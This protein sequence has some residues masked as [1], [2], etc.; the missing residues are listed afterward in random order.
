MPGRVKLD[1]P[2]FE[3]CVKKI[4]T[5]GRGFVETDSIATD[6]SSKSPAMSEFD[7]CLERLFNLVETYSNQVAD[8]AE[9]MRQ[10]AREF[11]KFDKEMRGRFHGHGGGHH[12]GS[13]N[14]PGHHGGPGNGPGPHGGP[15]GGPT[16]FGGNSAQGGGNGAFGGGGHGGG[17]RSYGGGGAGSFGHGGG[18]GIR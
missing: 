4:E 13:V 7:G 10:K 17:S 14:G 5:G 15:G 12:G 9:V 3:G 2:E 16:S 18:V 1:M 6:R 8:D 11:E